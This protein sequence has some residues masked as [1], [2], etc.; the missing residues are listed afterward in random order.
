MF[1]NFALRA[2][3]ILSNMFRKRNVKNFVVGNIDLKNVVFREDWTMA[4]HEFNSVCFH[5]FQLKT[6][7][8]TRHKIFKRGLR[9]I[10][11]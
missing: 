10:Q 3:K 2:Q 5:C 7:A 11:A 6:S 4:N 1:A 8:F 9:N